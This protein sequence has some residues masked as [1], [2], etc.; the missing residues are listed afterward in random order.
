MAFRLYE[1]DGKAFYQIGVH[2]SGDVYGLSDE[3]ILETLV[4]LFYMSTMLQPKVK[5]EMLKVRQGIKGLSV[6][7]ELTQCS[8]KVEINVNF[9]EETKDDYKERRSPTRR[10]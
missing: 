6:M 5:M 3:E 4:V 2:D 10:K 7:L 8:Q 1:G 9:D